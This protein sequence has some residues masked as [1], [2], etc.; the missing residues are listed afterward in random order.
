MGPIINRVLVVYELTSDDFGSRGVSRG[1]RRS[2]R[3]RAVTEAK[4][5]CSWLAKEL[6]LPLTNTEISESINRERSAFAPG[7]Q[8]CKELQARD[9]WLRETATRLLSELRA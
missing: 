1:D 2:R 7:V 5:L 6:E 9:K 3:A 4:D 8:R